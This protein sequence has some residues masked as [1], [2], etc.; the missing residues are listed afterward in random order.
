[1]CLLVSF[2]LTSALLQAENRHTLIDSHILYNERTGIEGVLIKDLRSALEVKLGLK[3]LI[4][5]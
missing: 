4:E 1:M 3:V 5:N 2:S